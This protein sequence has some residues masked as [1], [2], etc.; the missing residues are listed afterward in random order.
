MLSVTHARVRQALCS[1]LLLIGMSACTDN[2]STIVV[3]ADGNSSL[4]IEPPGF[5]VDAR[6]V[7]PENLSLFVT[8]DAG[9]GATQVDMAP[10]RPGVIWTGSIRVQKNSNVDL[11]AEWKETVD[12]TDLLL[13]RATSRLVNITGRTQFVLEDR[14][15]IT[16][17]PGFDADDDGISNLAERK[18]DSNPFIPE[19][20]SP[21]GVFPDVQI[22][23]HGGTE[24]IDGVYTNSYWQNA[25]FA[26]VNG[27]KLAIDNMIRDDS[28]DILENP[29]PDYQW[30]AT[31][32]GEYLV[33]YVWGK[34][35]NGSTI[36]INGD[37]P[38]EN[39]FF[40]DDSL[41]IY[42]DGNL[43]QNSQ[44]YDRVDDLLINIP[45]ARGLAP[46][47]QQNNSSAADKRIYRGGNVKDEVI[48]D[49]LDPNIVEFG[50]CFCGG[51]ERSTW[52][53]RIDLAAA[54]IT[55]GSTFGFE[56]QIN[57]DDDGDARDSKWAWAKPPKGPNQ[58]N[59]LADVTWRFPIHMGTARLVPF[60]RRSE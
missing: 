7:V 45:L 32:D 3:D 37:S 30:A 52:E 29:D 11:Y 60:T 9:G 17:G 57:Q 18:Q 49:V 36:N 54:N 22:I 13:A 21:N 5:V 43:S 33:L 34:A 47:Y 38:G 25:A 53:V 55:V 46:P 48:F 39:S 44:D 51:A 59:D 14:S 8:I 28:P 6:A 1:I 35:A 15:Y 10:Q 26:D 16:T 24:V 12:G 2:G 4:V 58:L 42:I 31:H 41:E 56:L 20:T 23:G 50:T 40:N 19:E 27:E